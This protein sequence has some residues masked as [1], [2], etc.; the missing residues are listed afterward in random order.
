MTARMWSILAG[1]SSRGSDRNDMWKSGPCPDIRASGA[2]A[3]AD[4]GAIG[5]KGLPPRRSA[6][7]PTPDIERATG[8]FGAVGLIGDGQLAD[9]R[10]RERTRR[11]PRVWIRFFGGFWG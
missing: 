10:V 6:Q 8:Y 5:L 4:Q 2:R 3:F 7:R 9:A 1:P 11:M